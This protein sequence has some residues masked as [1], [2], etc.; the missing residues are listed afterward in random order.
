MARANRC[1]IEARLLKQTLRDGQSCAPL[2]VSDRL[3]A[4][5]RKWQPAPIGQQDDITLLVIDVA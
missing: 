4:E 5:I 3:L 1:Q 2:E